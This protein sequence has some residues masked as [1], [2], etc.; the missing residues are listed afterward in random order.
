MIKKW[1]KNLVMTWKW[2]EIQ[3]LEVSNIIMKIKHSH[4]EIPLPH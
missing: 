4:I 2:S 1:K 3:A